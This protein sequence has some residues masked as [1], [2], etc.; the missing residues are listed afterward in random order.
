MILAF[1]TTSDGPL[2]VYQVSLNSLVYFL[3][4]APD[5]LFIAKMKKG[6]NSVNTVDRVMVFAMCNFP[7]GPLSVHQVSFNSLNCLL[8]EICSGQTFIG[9]MKK[10][11]NSINT[12]DRVMVLAL[13][14]CPHGPLPV[15]QVSFKLSSI[16]LEICSGQKCDR[17]TDGRTDKAATIC[18]PFGEHKKGCPM[19]P[20]MC[21]LRLL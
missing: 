17:R 20:H 21:W 13:C 11:S 7:Y 4:H 2:S 10:G 12:V 6:S 5:K 3:R 16:L 9:K 15:Y 1:C 19:H 18:S 14:N 8:S